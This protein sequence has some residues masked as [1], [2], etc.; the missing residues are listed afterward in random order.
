MRT[1]NNSRKESKI[2]DDDLKELLGRVTRGSHNHYI[3]TC[4]L[5]G[6]AKHF[7]IQRD[8]QLFDCKKCG[9]EGNIYKLLLL[10]GKLFLLGEYKSIDRSKITLLSELMLN[11][12]KEIDINVEERKPPIGFKRVFE[13]DYLFKRKFKKRNFKKFKIGYT[14]L[15]PS[16]KDYVIF[17]IEED[18]V[19]KGYVAR[20]NWSK[21]KIKRYE[22]RT[23]KRKPRYLND[24]GAKFSHLLA[25]FD[26][27]NDNTETVILVEGLID[28][29]TLDNIL[30]LD[31]HDEVKC[32]ATFGKKISEFQVLKLLS[33]GVKKIILIYDDDAITQMKK[34]GSM[35]SQFFDAELTYT[36]GGDINESS[37]KE[38]IEMF[39]RLQSVEQFYRK[40]VKLK[41]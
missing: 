1:T 10:T 27:V 19:N 2:S 6:K 37:K 7:Y 38:V 18:G 21:E 13:D 24:K 28:K 26:E 11:E 9:E 41:L 34:F 35:L 30:R 12:E 25:G 16:L 14:N 32:C 4:P 33:K 3:A 36:I 8:T 17:L 20:L 5:C 23:G 29:N 15:V 31:L 22:K 40:N 39:D